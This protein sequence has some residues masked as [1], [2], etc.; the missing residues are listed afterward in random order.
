MSNVAYAVVPG[1]QRHLL[2]GSK[3]L[4]AANPHEQIEVTLE[5]R[6]KAPLPSLA[7]R[8]AQPMSREEFAQK[9]GASDAD[10]A[11]VKAVLKTFGLDVVGSDAAARTVEVVGPV[12]AMEQAFAVRLFNFAHEH[13]N[14][15]GRSGVIHVPDE[16]NGIVV[17]VSGLDDR[18]VI[19]RRRR[20]L[21]HPARVVQG[22]NTAVSGFLP[23]D[24]AKHYQFPDGTGEGQCIGILEFGGQI[25]TD[26]LQQFCTTAGIDVPNVFQVNVSGSVDDPGAE[27]G[28]EVMLDIEV[29]AGICPKAKIP[30]YFGKTFDERSWKLAIATAIHDAQNK[31]T[32]L[33]ISWGFDEEDFAPTAGAIDRVNTR[34]QEAAMMGITICVSSGDDGSADQTDSGAPGN[35]I[36]GRAHVDFPASSEFVLA[37]GGTNLQVRQG[38]VTESA[39]KDGNGR[40]FFPGGT[41]SGGASGGGV[42]GHIKRPSFQ[43]GI[44]IEPINPGSIKGRVIPDVAAH[45]QSDGVR[46]GYFTVF[47]DPQSGDVVA[48]PVG[49]TS[50]AAPLWAALITRINAI[51]EKQKG[52]GKRAGYLTPILYQAGAEG[53]PV[54]TAVCKDI[55][56]G[57]NNSATIGGFRSGPGFDAVTGWGSPIGANLLA[58]LLQLV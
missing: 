26:A 8:P 16:L 45:A 43:N 13:A 29:V 33:S 40:R 51:L 2:P 50:A 57:D 6:H 54:G 36:D 20:H 9:Y 23:A 46:T 53:K 35:G 12:A 56:K 10:I 11:K 1:T 31:P 15:R 41:G 28:V 48:A 42:S 3:L 38:Q 39:W 18:P 17:D 30:V 14:Y 58:A 7:G 32:V 37:V 47:I 44:T 5:L 52:P 49:G 21:Q 55:T 24:L 27:S 22:D 19:H 4:H 25:E 34:F